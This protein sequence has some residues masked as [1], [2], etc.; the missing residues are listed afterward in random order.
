MY[1]FYLHLLILNALV[2]ITQQRSCTE[3]D[4]GKII[5]DCNLNKEREGKL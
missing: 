5:T 1:L 4:I 3:K 2:W